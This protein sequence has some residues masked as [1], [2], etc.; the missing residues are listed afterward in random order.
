MNNGNLCV[1]K[2][3]F[4]NFKQNTVLYLNCKS[5]LLLFK[6]YT[7]SK[8]VLYKYIPLTTSVFGGGGGIT[9]FAL[10]RHYVD[11]L[12]QNDVQNYYNYNEHNT[13]S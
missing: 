2:S 8:I 13:T 12:N 4:L 5:I 6:Y 1:L 10:V 3:Q 11:K 9:Q 7:N